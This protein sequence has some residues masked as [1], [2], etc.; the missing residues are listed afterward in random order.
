MRCGWMIGWWLIAAAWLAGCGVETRT[1]SS[2]WDALAEFADPKPDPDDAS[3]FGDRAGGQGWAIEIERFEGDR[4]ASDAQ[5]LTLMLRDQTSINELWWED[6]DGVAT[7]WSGRYRDPTSAEAQAALRRVR[8]ATID[9]EAR[10]ADAEL[11]PLIGGGRRFLDPF[12]LKQYTGFFSLQIAFYDETYEGDPRQAAEQHARRL[13][14]DG[15]EAYF[16]HGPH[17]SLVTIG[18]FSEHDFTRRGTMDAYGPR[19]R[20]LQAKFPHNLR[21]GKEKVMDEIEGQDL[22][23]QPSF[24]VR[25]F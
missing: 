1:I 12:N 22:G 8:R 24:V 2:S 16:Y 13:R 19:I 7:V 15:E 23:A 14:E 25:V 4:R 10:F 9:G 18:L 3:R 17:R 20:E 11:K 21:H 5:Y 6:I